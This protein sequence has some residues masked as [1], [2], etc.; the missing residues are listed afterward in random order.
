[1]SPGEGRFPVPLASNAPA[2]LWRV[3]WPKPSTGF[4]LDQGL[5]VA[6]V[7]SQVV[8]PYATNTTDISII[9]PS[10]LGNR[11]YRLRFP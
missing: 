1:M 6:G 4:A 10:P 9:V 11:F 8:F 2:A 5:T 7:W 3:F